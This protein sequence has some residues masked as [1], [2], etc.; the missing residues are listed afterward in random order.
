MTVGITGIEH[1][2]GHAISKVFYDPVSINENL[3]GL[4]D[5]NVFI[6]NLAKRNFQEIWFEK[7]FNLWVDKP[8]TIVNIISSVV[9]DDVNTLG[10]Y[11]ETKIS[12]YNK[13]KET[14]KKHP[15]KLARVINIY[16]STLSSNKQFEYLNKVDI[17]AI[18]GLIKVLVEM[19]QD[20]EVRDV[21]IY[22]TSLNKQFNK[23]SVL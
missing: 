14:L 17:D 5:C 2:L 7:V 1:K 16:P 23:K 15:D 12:F 8:K 19:P 21:C 18:A 11:G 3:D 4:F 6:N 10:S 22:P 13:V 9:F 20:I